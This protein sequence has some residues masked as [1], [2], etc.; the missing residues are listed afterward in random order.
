M[1]LEARPNIEF[2]QAT[3]QLLPLS[4]L[5]YAY[6]LFPGRWAVMSLPMSDIGGVCIGIYL[7]ITRVIA[8]VGFII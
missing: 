3:T 7:S 1:E 5:P 6:V 8:L 4:P 2:H